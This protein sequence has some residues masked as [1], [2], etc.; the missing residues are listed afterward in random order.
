MAG[1]YQVALPWKS[2]QI[3]FP[4]NQTMASRRLNQL[5]KRFLKDP[6]FFERYRK[7]IE[8][9]LSNRY[10]QLV[11]LDAGISMKTWYLLHHAVQE[12]FREVFDCGASYK[13][14]SLNSQLLQGPDQ[15]GF[16]NWSFAEV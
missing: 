16:F 13:D 6:A 5:K 8:R 3:S 10:A 4:N 9:Y 2:D 15:T 7:K 1:H 14:T 12:K 11:S